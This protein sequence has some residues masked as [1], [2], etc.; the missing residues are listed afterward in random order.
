MLTDTGD[1]VLDPFA[2]SCVTGEVCETLQRRFVCCE[3]V[4]EY[5]RGAIHRFDQTRTME[6]R[7]APAYSINHPAA[8]W[9]NIPQDVLPAD[10]GKE[11]PKKLKGYGTNGKP[12][13]LKQ[14][15]LLEPRK[16]YRAE[17]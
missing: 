16:K 4:E 17:N 12:K 1:L 14:Q 10:G 9:T 6:K 5:L 2:G 8:M 13:R 3:L 11:R 7:T 15:V